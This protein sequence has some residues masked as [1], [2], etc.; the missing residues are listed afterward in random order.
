MTDWKKTVLASGFS[1]MVHHLMNGKWAIISAFQS[2]PEESLQGL[3]SK[4]RTEVLT[5]NARENLARDKAFKARLVEMGYGFIPGKGVWGG[6]PE[7]SLFIPGMEK[8]V[9]QKLA[10][11]LSQQAYIF[12]V[13]GKYKIL[14]TKGQASFGEGETGTDFHQF[15]EQEMAEAPNR[16]E[17]KGRKWILDPKY[18]ERARSDEMSKEKPV[19]DKGISLAGAFYAWNPDV[20]WVMPRQGVIVV[21]AE[22]NG[23]VSGSSINLDPGALAIYLPLKAELEASHWVMKN[24]RLGRKK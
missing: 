17:T 23:L 12:G 7:N 20:K 5:R 10:E 24:C 16:T 13:G 4:D 1:R 2:L 21:K 19:E 11:E 8:D 9:A 15:S 14:E 3:P 6:A 22:K 18:R